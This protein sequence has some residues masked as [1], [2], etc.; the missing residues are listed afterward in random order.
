MPEIFISPEAEPLRYCRLFPH[1]VIPETSK[2]TV[3]DQRWRLSKPG[4]RKWCNI[5]L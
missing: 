1:H 2:P 5:Q 4:W 3:A